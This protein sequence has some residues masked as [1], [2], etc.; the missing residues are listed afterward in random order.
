MSVSVDLAK[1][2]Q[3][4]DELRGMVGSLRATYGEVPAVARVTN[5]VDRLV[6]DAEELDQLSPAPVRATGNEIH[7]LTDEPY[8]P[9]LWTD[10]DDEGVGGYH[11][12]TK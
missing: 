6:I 7:P 5:D 3:T 2:H 10:T 12:P 11:G 4:V 1:F 8:D 9:A